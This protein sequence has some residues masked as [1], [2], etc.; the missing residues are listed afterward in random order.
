MFGKI[1]C[2]EQDVSVRKSRCTVLKYSGY[3]AVSASLQVAEIMLRCQKFDL[4]VLSK[5]PD[6]D[7][8]R[9]INFADG[10]DLL[11]LD[12]FTT[13]LELLTLVAQRLDRQRKA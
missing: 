7:L 5:L 2:V 1:L 4:I 8:N 10:A 3:D 13:P 12:G 11:V 9:I 6:Y